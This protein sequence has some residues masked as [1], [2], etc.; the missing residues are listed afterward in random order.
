MKK[1]LFVATAEMNDM[2]RRTASGNEQEAIQA[3]QA[4]AVSMGDPIRAGIMAG[5]IWSSIFTTIP[6]PAGSPP[7]WPLDILQPGT[8]KDYVAYTIPAH[9][10]IPERRVESSYI[11]IPTF[12]VGNA[13]DWLLRIARNTRWDLVGAATKLYQDGFVKKFND[14]AF[15]VLMGAVVDRN[16]MV[17]DS[18]ASASQ[19]TKRLVSLGKTT[20][21]RNGGGNTSSVNRRTLTDMILSV[22]GMED[23]RD[24]GVDQVD[25]ITRR[26]IYTA[27]DGTVTRIFNVNLHGL[28]EL[29][30]GCEYQNYFTGE[31]GGSLESSD[32]ELA[33][34]LDLSVDNVFVR[35][36]V[37]EVQTFA[38]PT[39]HRAQ[40]AGIYGWCEHG[41]GV[42]D[43][44][45]VIGLSY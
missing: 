16:I 33:I 8:E 2:L 21:A 29:G 18:A 17:Y 20:M 36:T 12:S 27:P 7:E 35:P 19:F 9:G 24:W 28:V 42:L 30:E 22:E 4:L 39:L 45:A 6:I 15:H 43:N 1:K 10:R 37:E 38:D 34:G 26:E 11:T 41:W 23:I 31:L 44:R 13:I 32:K 5:D 3:M 14:D 25:D 40:K